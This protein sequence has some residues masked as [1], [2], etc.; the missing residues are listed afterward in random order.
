[1]EEDT[2]L[3]KQYLEL[4]IKLYSPFLKVYEEKITYMKSNG[5]WDYKKISD[6]IGLSVQA[7]RKWMKRVEDNVSK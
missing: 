6:D 3:C 4:Q 5:K 1:M 7:C 2:N